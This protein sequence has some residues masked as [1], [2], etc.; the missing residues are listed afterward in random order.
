MPWQ[1]AGEGFISH[2]VRKEIECV[3]DWGSAPQE[4]LVCGG[5]TL[6]GG[7][8]GGQRCACKTRREDVG[9]K[10]AGSISCSGL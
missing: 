10:K 7:L 4:F 1:R 6:L 9:I 8:L 2:R 5:G 3:G